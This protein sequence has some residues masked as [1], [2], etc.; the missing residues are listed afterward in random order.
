MSLRWVIISY[1]P[2]HGPLESRDMGRR[3][4]TSPFDHE[5]SK[6]SPWCWAIISQNWGMSPLSII[7]ER[8]TK[9]LPPHL[10]SEKIVITQGNMIWIEISYNWNWFVGNF[11]QPTYKIDMCPFT[12]FNS[13]CL[14]TCFFNIINKK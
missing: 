11:I 14:L 3:S 7:R 8:H 1:S 6:E 4:Y 9:S 5:D 10:C 13:M 12:C 2:Q